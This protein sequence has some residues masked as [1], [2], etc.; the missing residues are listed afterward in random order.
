MNQYNS[1]HTGDF[2][3]SFL[4]NTNISM[5]HEFTNTTTNPPENKYHNNNYK[6]MQHVNNVT[7]YN[8]EESFK[9]N[10]PLI[11]S[12]DFSNQNNVLHNNMAPHLLSERIVDNRIHI[13]SKDRHMLT[14]T[15]P[16]KYN[17]IFGPPAK[18]FVNG[19]P[20][21]VDPLNHSLGK[22]PTTLLFDAP[23]TPH[24]KVS[25]KN[26]KYIKFTKIILPRYPQI[27]KDGLTY[28]IDTSISLSD[29]RY[30]I[31]SIKELDSEC[32]LGTNIMTENGFLLYPDIITTN[33]IICDASGVNKIFQDNL[34]SNLNKLTIEFKYNNGDPISLTIVDTLG[35]ILNEPFDTDI[36]NKNNINNLNNDKYQNNMTLLIGTI[37][38]NIDTN[39]KYDL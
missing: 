39:T 18:Q 21:W 13:D 31:L 14:Y 38:N 8:F 32:N 7:G 35:N 25:F 22:I 2:P 19:P 6:N 15:N 28:T 3:H 10:T 36:N 24:I 4:N 17:V 16:F 23:P 1:T 34:L 20:T 33:Y 26:I 29:E 11:P 27:I 9:Q 30:I 5:N 37:K 12:P